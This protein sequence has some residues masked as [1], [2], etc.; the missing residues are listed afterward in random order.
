VTLNDTLDY[1]GAT[2]NISSRISH[3]SRGDDVI[4]SPQM[5]QDQAV[6]VIVPKIGTLEDFESNLHGYK[7]RF[8][9]GRLVFH[10]VRLDPVPLIANPPR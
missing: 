9:L 5:L 2:V 4:P 10:R 3:L 1:F 6:Q 8:E 7:E